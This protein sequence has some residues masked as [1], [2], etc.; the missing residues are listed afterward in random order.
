VKLCDAE[1]REHMD[2]IHQVACGGRRQ[3]DGGLAGEQKERERL[4]QVKADGGIGVAGIA[5]RDVLADEQS[6][7][8]PRVV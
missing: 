2:R 8:P 1:K 6:K 4:L 7:S 3:R 5:A